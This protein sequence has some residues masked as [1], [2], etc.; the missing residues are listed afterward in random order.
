MKCRNNPPTHPRLFQTLN[1]VRGAPGARSRD[2]SLYYNCSE[3]VKLSPRR[4]F[5][6]VLVLISAKPC[7]MRSSA[8]LCFFSYQFQPCL[9]DGEY[10]SMS[11]VSLSRASF[12]SSMNWDTDWFST[13][14]LVGWEVRLCSLH[15][16]CCRF[17]LCG[18]ER[19]RCWRE[20][21]YYPLRG[22]P[23][24]PTPPGN[25]PCLAHLLR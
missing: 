3:G 8:G 2:D 5:Y 22:S 4:H 6:P 20:T 16:C 25:C 14:G 11:A 1:G 12:C 19:R 15:Q 9:L 7:C 23:P 17:T 13:P 10:L 21:T 24:P 18:E